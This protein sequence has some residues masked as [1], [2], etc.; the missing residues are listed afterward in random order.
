MYFRIY[1]TVS[2]GT[3][4]KAIDWMRYITSKGIKKSFG[5][6]LHWNFHPL[7]LCAGNQI[8]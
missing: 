4:K 2:F 1:A 6:L 5:Y 3:W 8:G 7:S